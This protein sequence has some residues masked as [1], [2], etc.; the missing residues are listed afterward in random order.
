M[1]YPT[2]SGDSASTISGSPLFKVKFGNLIAEPGKETSAFGALVKSSGLVGTIDGFSYTPEL[3]DQGFFLQEMNRRTGK[4]SAPS[5]M[6]AKQL[7]I[8]LTLTVLHTRPLGWRDG[9]WRDKNNRFPYG[10]PS[11]RTRKSNGE[12][13]ARAGKAATGGRGDATTPTKSAE[14]QSENDDAQERQRSDTD[15]AVNNANEKKMLG[16]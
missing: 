12:E 5:M 9:Q 14:A 6:Y 11:A 15:K 8:S 7:N 3:V 10:V 16:G 13:K 2:Y 1:L 4:Q